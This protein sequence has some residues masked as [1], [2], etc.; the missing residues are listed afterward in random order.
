M[1][2]KVLVRNLLNNKLCL[3]SRRKLNLAP[4]SFSVI[5]STCQ[6]K[7]LRKNKIIALGTIVIGS[8][9]YISKQTALCEKDDISHELQTSY[10]EEEEKSCPFCRFFL[11]SPCRDSFKLWHRCIK[12]GSLE[13]YPFAFTRIL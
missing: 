4:V 9:K 13:F 2:H 12:V 1:I 5:V 3:G 8:L 11:E 10:D 7:Q 6:L